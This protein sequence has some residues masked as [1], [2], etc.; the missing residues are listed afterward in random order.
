[1]TE[2]AHSMRLW[3]RTKS[4]F[5]NKKK[6]TSNQVETPQNQFKSR[7]KKHLRFDSIARVF[8]HVFM[9]IK[10]TQNMFIDDLKFK[11][12]HIRS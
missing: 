12:R 11:I 8:R 9:Q 10:A 4:I 1:M 5:M 3:D 2:E 6:K 7:K